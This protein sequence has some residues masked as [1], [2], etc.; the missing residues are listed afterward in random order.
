MRILRL[1]SQSSWKRS[2]LLLWGILCVLALPLFHSH[3]EANHQHGDLH[4]VHATVHSVFSSDFLSSYPAE[5][6]PEHPSLSGHAP[7]V[8]DDPEIGFSLTASK[9]H[10]TGKPVSHALRGEV[11]LGM[12]FR[13]CA[14]LSFSVTKS[15]WVVLASGDSSRAPPSV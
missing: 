7:S 15:S 11:A 6:S 9:D 14:S 1:L 12:G 3:P 4:H 10:D 2:V 8:D 13:P 5:H